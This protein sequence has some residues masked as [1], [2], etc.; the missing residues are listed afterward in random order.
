MQMTEA[1]GKGEVKEKEK[2]KK[3]GGGQIEANNDKQKKELASNEGSK[4]ALH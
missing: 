1:V 4:S 3:G 2:K